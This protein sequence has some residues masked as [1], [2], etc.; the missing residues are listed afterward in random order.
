EWLA[1][2][3]KSGRCSAKVQ[4]PHNPSFALSPFGLP[5]LFRGVFFG[6]GA[7]ATARARII[8]VFLWPLLQHRQ[9]IISHP[10]AVVP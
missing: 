10:A 3:I 9:V 4:R 6:I 7:A 2:R 8:P 1:F 5:P